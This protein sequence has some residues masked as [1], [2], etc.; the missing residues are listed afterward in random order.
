MVSNKAYTVINEN[1]KNRALLM[2]DHGG[3]FIPEYYANLGLNK[4]T[5]SSHIAIDIGAAKVTEYISFRLDIP[6][7]VSNFS[8]LYID[9]NRIPGSPGSIPDVSNQVTVP[10]NQ[11]ISEKE[12][13]LRLNSS[14]IPYHSKAKQMFDYAENLY[15]KISYISIH[16]FTPNLNGKDRPWHIGVLYGE[17][18]AMAM[19][20]IEILS[21]NE[22][23]KIGLNKPYSAVDP[24]GYGY[25][26]YG[27]VSMRPN[28]TIEIR[29]DLIENDQGVNIWS[30]FICNALRKVLINGAIFK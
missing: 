14:F 2:C 16:S 28:L 5:I 26:N 12:K 17:D 25:E 22:K 18:N 15:E 19:E 27:F 4:Q 24:R 23:I 10:G 1:G 13:L 20:F 7:I 9:L 21:E 30:E 11:N 3:N 29:Q 6:A 8:R